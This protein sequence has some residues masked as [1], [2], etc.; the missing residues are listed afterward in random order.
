MVHTVAGAACAWKRRFGTAP[1]VPGLTGTLQ[2]IGSFITGGWLLIANV[3]L[4]KQ[5]WRPG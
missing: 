4:S 2:Q 3:P 5:W 1:P